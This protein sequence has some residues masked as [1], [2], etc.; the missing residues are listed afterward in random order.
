MES[1]LVIHTSGPGRPCSCDLMFHGS[2]GLP[3]SRRTSFVQIVYLSSE[4]MR[5][6]SMSKRHARMTGRFDFGDVFIVKGTEG[7]VSTGKG[8]GRNCGAFVCKDVELRTRRKF[9]DP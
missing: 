5:R 3:N 1:W 9:H 7:I 2:S 6:P 4:S 8:G